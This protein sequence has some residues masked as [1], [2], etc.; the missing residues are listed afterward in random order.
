MRSDLAER[1]LKALM[2]WDVPRFAHEVARLQMVASL[3]Y[4]EY[5]GYRPGVKFAENIHA[6]TR[7]TMLSPMRLA[8]AL[9]ERPTVR[10]LPVLLVA[11]GTRVISRVRRMPFNPNT[12]S[13]R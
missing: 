1:L 10:P 9:S 8:G 13:S 12:G 4:D 2:D 11:R 5:G 3:K 6:A 7:V